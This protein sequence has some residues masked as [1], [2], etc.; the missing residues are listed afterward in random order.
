[1]VIPEA[2]YLYGFHYPKLVNKGKQAV[3]IIYNINLASARAIE[4]YHKMYN[5]KIGIVLNLT[6]A[7]PRS[8]TA[9]DLDTSKLVD[10]FYNRSFLDQAVHGE[11]PREV[12]ELLTQNNVLWESTP[13]ELKIIHDNTIDFLGVNYYH[14]K[15]VKVRETIL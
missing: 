14:P 13:E 10:A 12:I 7:Y 9:E 15:R 2:G 6:P 5:G 8:Q 3:Q 1:M 11:F 4:L